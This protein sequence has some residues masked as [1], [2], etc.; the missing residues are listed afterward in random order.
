MGMYDKLYADLCY[1]VGGKPL[2]AEAKV[3]E[4]LRPLGERKCGFDDDWDGGLPEIC[5][6]KV[7]E[8]LEGGELEPITSEDSALDFA[9]KNWLAAD[10][11]AHSLEIDLGVAKLEIAD[12]KE[13]LA[14]LGR[15]NNQLQ[16][17]L[18]GEE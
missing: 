4:A 7:R 9:Q 3:V 8:R 16:D 14:R 1:I 11:R 12:L 17:K 13:R 6:D 18:W 5:P 10:R 15:A 2:Q